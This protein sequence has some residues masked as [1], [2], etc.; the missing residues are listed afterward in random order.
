MKETNRHIFFKVMA[1][2][3]AGM[4]IPSASI[5]QTSGR[6][7]NV[8]FIAVDDL[9]P[10][11][12]C[13]GWDKIQS[14]NMDRL[15]SHGV[16]FERAYCQQAVCMATR[17]SLMSGF[18]P[19]KGE[20]YK[21]GPLFE[22][23]PDVLTL[24]QY[25]MNNGYETV[26]LGKIYHYESDERTGWSI[27]AFHPE[28]QWEGRGYLSEEA[29]QLVREYTKMN[30]NATR[31]GMGPAYE[32][33]DVPDN[34]YPDG[35]V[36][37]RAIQELNRLKDKPFF[38]A[39]GFVKPHLPFNAPKKYWDL[40]SE[41]DIKLADNPFAPDGAPSIAMTGWGELRGYAGMPN[42]G[43]M[44]DEDALKLIHAYYACISYTDA[45][46]GN[47]LDELDRL[48]LTD[49]TIIVLWGDHGWKL[50]EHG[51]WCKHTNFELDTHVP[52]MVSAPG[53]KAR[54]R[55]TKALTEFVDIYPT[56]C[57]LAGIDL[58]EHLEG[59]S[60]VPLLNHPDRPWKK[61]AFSQY[62]RGKDRDKM[63]YTMR[64]DRYRYTEWQDIQT[65]NVEARELYDH[66]NDP[67][68]NTNVVGNP[69]KKATVAALAKMLKDGYQSA[70]PPID[71]E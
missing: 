21:Q 31:K 52:L 16:L 12:G 54:G 41:D 22:C 2:L 40:Y 36:A 47:V 27:P 67:E 29:K 62:P 24:N 11:L 68:E 53:M 64:T 8:L 32:H 59:T 3:A 4:M 26:S 55:K 5:A 45:Q 48:N 34:A 61:A 65:G 70:L 13:Y 10:Q 33:P 56:L 35:L 19:D 57:E 60:M 9:R 43:P 51:M 42:K 39:V 63:G 71:S 58:P 37:E 18:R 6:K 23:V 44:P 17:A 30:P 25:F 69:E 49:N 28:G 38:L 66:L 7:P 50:G 20:I 14:P 15:A 1:L 46:I